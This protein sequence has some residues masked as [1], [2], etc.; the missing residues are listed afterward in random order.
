MGS[1]QS[2][3]T[4]SEITDAPFVNKQHGKHSAGSKL[5]PKTKPTIENKLISLP[6]VS[7]TTT[8]SDDNDDDDSS[9]EEENDDEF[10]GKLF[11]FFFPISFR[12][13]FFILTDRRSIFIHSF[14]SRLIHVH[15]LTFIIRFV[16]FCFILF[17]SLKIQK[18]NSSL[19]VSL[20]WLMLRI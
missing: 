18:Q 3:P 12:F 6:V 20:S 17:Y 4:S 2:M 16:L 8:E 13:F 1:S 10:D 7:T 5:G 19:N 9:D 15:P 11:L 14:V